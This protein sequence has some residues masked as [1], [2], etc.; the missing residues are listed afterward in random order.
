[1]R[2]VPLDWV[3]FLLADVRGGLGAYVIVYLVTGAHWSP[4]TMGAVLTVS[5]LAGI[6]LHPSVGALIDAIRAKRALLIAGTIVLS[7]CGLVVVRAPIL[8]VVFG[9]DLSMAVLGGVFAPVV[10]AMTVG[11]CDRRALAA[12]LGRN[13]VFDRAGNVFMA[14]LVGVVGLR[15]SQAAPFYL[16]PVFAALTI[17]AVLAIPAG[18]IDHARARG[19]VAEQDGAIGRPHAWGDLLRSP[20][21]AVFAAAS[22]IFGFANA[23]LLQLVA[24][25]LALAH[26]GYE[27][28]VTSAAIIVTQLATIPMALLVMRA[29]LI[30]RKPL[31]IVAFAAV[32]LRALLCAALS[33]PFWLLGAQALDGIGG[34][35]YDALLPLTLADLTRGSGR[36]SLARGVLGAIQGIGGSTGQGAAG[37]LVAA[38]GYGPAF[39]ALAAIAFLAMALMVV[40]MPET[41]SSPD[42]RARPAG[43]G[44]G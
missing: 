36:Y 10:A 9:A 23:P 8:P 6:L 39:L 42:D 41:R 1:M 17:V 30:G 11:L 21:I 18:A 33:D 2:L 38:F 32:P 26:P 35:L 22:A 43:A 16:L 44:Q 27:S 14:A 31:L 19:L 28:G 5:G 4:A 13:A 24:Q 3:N 15:F 29:N 20:P 34:G 25:K 37:A 40:A 12:R 7:L